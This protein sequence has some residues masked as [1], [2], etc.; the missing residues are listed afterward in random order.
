MDVTE[1]S[2]PVPVRISGGA[3]QTPPPLSANGSN[4][5]ETSA[6]CIYTYIH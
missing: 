4:E 1:A 3:L 2:L 6:I 5:G